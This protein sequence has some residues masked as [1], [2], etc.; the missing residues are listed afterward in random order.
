MT[1][2]ASV[3]SANGLKQVK[4][5]EADSEGITQYEVPAL[6]QHVQPYA[7]KPFVCRHT[8]EPLKVFCHDDRC[9]TCLVCP[10]QA[11]A[12]HKTELL[13]DFCASERARLDGKRRQTDDLLHALNQ[14]QEQ[15][16]T[17]ATR[18][19][20]QVDNAVST[21]VSALNSRRRALH[22]DIRRRSSEMIEALEG[23]LTVRK[24]ELHRLDSAKLTLNLLSNG[25]GV[26][27]EGR[28]GDIL[29]GKATYDEFLALSMPEMPPA[30]TIKQLLKLT[31]PLKMRDDVLRFG[32]TAETK[33]AQPLVYPPKGF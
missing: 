19:H 8:G 3:T 30:P 21:L 2:G 27:P 16:P 10:T 14:L 32:W 18:L 22:D 5:F 1:S 33:D 17:N 26:A 6:T 23:E 20:V 25:R 7:L 13:R 31:L 24:T 15:V 29:R 4:E 12:G 11:H 28:I 9:M